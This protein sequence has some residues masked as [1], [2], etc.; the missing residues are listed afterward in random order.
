VIFFNSDQRFIWLTYG[1]TWFI[2]DVLLIHLRHL[3]S[4]WLE[5][6]SACTSQQTQF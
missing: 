4:P 5:K 3:I 1:T 6:H 2:S